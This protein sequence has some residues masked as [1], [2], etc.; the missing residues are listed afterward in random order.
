MALTLPYPSLDFVPLDVLTAAELN[1]IV[2]NYTYIA[3]QFPPSLQYFF[4]EEKTPI[5][6]SNTTDE[7][8]MSLTITESG[9]YFCTTTGL[10]MSD[11]AVMHEVWLYL[12]KNG[13]GFGSGVG[14]YG[15]QQG[16]I[17]GLSSLTTNSISQFT[18]GDTLSM[19]A[20]VN[21]ARTILSN[22]TLIAIR[23]G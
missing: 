22:R 2:A 20:S 4:A 13:S 10:F 23:I 17:T 8:K 18:A 6:I 11:T 19:G 9:L 3:S 16:D 1:E 14:L 12:M 5:T 21:S 7:A 15:N